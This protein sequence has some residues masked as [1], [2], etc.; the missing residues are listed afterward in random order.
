MEGSLVFLAFIVMLLGIMDWSRMM[1]AYNSVSYSAREATRY[2]I[3]HGSSSGHAATSTDLTNVVKNATIGLDPSQ[4]AVT[5]TWNP[6]NGPGSSV[7]VR[8][9]YNF[10]P[11]APYMPSLLTLNSSSTMVISQ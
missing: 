3:V 9:Q 2:A 1:L 6:N 7:T 4:I 11:I 8:V 5:S 10:Q